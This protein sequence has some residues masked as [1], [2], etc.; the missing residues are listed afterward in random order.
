MSDA[1]TRHKKG[2]PREMRK[3]SDTIFDRIY[4]YYFNKKTNVALN[5]EEEA[6]R[7][8]WDFAWKLLANMY[9]RRQVVEALTQKYNH[10]H[11]SIAYDDVN[12]AMMLFGDPRN[13]N[14]EAKK[15]LAEE[16]I[17]KG[18]KKAWDDQDLDAYERLIG[19][20]NKLN[21]LEDG[22]SENI[23]ELMKQLRPHQ[24]VIVANMDELKTEISK[25]QEDLIQDI[26][27]EE[28]NEGE[29]N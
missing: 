15:A 17:T 14:K 29:G 6:I 3:V 1:L 2:E 26:D 21:S 11:K 8:R 12:K 18:I 23:E 20:Y 22:H 24:V 4:K 25:L 7:D 5:D 10:I 13:A 19:R 27:H 16:W 9:T 28:I